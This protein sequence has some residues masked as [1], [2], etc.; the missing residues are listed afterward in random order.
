MRRPYGAGKTPRE[1]IPHG[2]ADAI[3]RTAAVFD[4]TDDQ[5]TVDGLPLVG[6]ALTIERW[7][8]RTAAAHTAREAP[9]LLRRHRTALR[10]D[11]AGTF[12]FALGTDVLTTTT[13]HI[14][15]DW[16][17]WGAV[18]DPA[19]ATQLLYRD[20]VEAARNTDYL[21]PA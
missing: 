2:L 13:T 21:T 19:T 7:A 15:T 8:T 6:S 14:D 16:Y 17:H 10:Y 3:V 20:G 18:L 4:S 5:V 12:S 11:Q 1:R 9:A